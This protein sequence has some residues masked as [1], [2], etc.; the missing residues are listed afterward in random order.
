MW[1]GEAPAE[2]VFGCS[3]GILPANQDDG[4][5]FERWDNRRDAGATLEK[6]SIMP[7]SRKW[8]WILA[9]VP[10]LGLG[11]LFSKFLPWRMET[12]YGCPA[13]GARAEKTYLC[14]APLGL[15]V[16][17]EGIS[18]YWR[19]N[20]EAGHRHDWVPLATG[21]DYLL[22]QGVRDHPGTFHLRWMLED[23]YE[24][25]VLRALPSPSA[26]KAFMTDLWRIGSHDRNA[27]GNVVCPIRLAYDENPKRT[28]WPAVLR[29]AGCDPVTGKIES[30]K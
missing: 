25:A 15:H 17:N 13:C 6:S 2:P 26:R 3:A 7:R 10:I 23:K 24:L 16:T 5:L 18:G 29:K 21:V 20:V 11:I 1:E 4:A 30:K 22:M 27:C 9:V 12:S 14:L 19:K 28:D 8:R